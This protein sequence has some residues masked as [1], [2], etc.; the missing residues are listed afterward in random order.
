[1]CFGCCDDRLWTCTICFGNQLLSL[2]L[3]FFYSGITSL[4]P[5]TMLS[6]PDWKKNCSNL[7]PLLFT[8]PSTC[9]VYFFRMCEEAIRPKFTFPKHGEPGDNK[10]KYKQ[11]TSPINAWKISFSC[12]FTS[13]W[14]QKEGRI[15]TP[16]N[17][18]YHFMLRHMNIC[19]VSYHN[20]FRD[21]CGKT[22]Y[23]VI[24]YEVFKGHSLRT[25]DNISQHLSS[26]FHSFWQLINACKEIEQYLSGNSPKNY[27]SIGWSNFIK[28]N[29]GIF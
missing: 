23:F 19:I 16:F 9:A 15:Y 8:I 25:Y 28:E 6:L 3:M 7:L 29:M 21:C 4:V 17:H 24:W 1:M 27:D 5:L 18:S 13:P 12:W 14:K 2:D 20:S 22:F 10:I 11:Q 26:Y